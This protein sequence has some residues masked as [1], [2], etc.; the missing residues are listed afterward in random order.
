MASKTIHSVQWL[1]RLSPTPADPMVLAGDA[2]PPSILTRAINQTMEHVAVASVGDNHLQS[3]LV[4]RDCTESDLKNRSNPHE[5]LNSRQN[6]RPKTLKK[7]NLK[8]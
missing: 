4:P 7:I 1:R 3:L 2:G 5:C 6:T 8:R